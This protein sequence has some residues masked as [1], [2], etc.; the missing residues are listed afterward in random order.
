[1]TTGVPY[2]PGWYG[3]R[4]LFKA[5]VP[6]PTVFKIGKVYEKAVQVDDTES[7]YPKREVLFAL[8]SERFAQNIEANVRSIAAQ[9]QRERETAEDH[10]RRI[11]FELHYRM[12][13]RG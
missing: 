12:Y 9:V 11:L 6:E 10:G 4:V 5:G 1:M 8:P 13:E 3:V 2:T 7:M